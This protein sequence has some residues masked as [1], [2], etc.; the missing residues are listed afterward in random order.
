MQ[1]AIL[2]LI[3]GLLGW[4]G[5]HLE[6]WL[7]R[8]RRRATLRAALAAEILSLVEM[9]R[10]GRYEEELR[11]FASQLVASPEPRKFDSYFVHA[12]QSYFSVFEAN[13]GDIGELDAR[14][15]VE[16]IAFY[17]QARS[18]LDS[19]APELAPAV[20]PNTPEAS[21][22]HYTLRADTLAR[23]CDFG[24]ALAGRLASAEVAAHIVEV[25]KALDATASSV[26]P[27]GA[28]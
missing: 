15:A 14:L 18:W 3:G 27:A 24:T 12:P 9:V 2:V 8:L 4:G 1:E 5:A 20:G 10:R 22:A 13:A 7:Q 26:P 16:V 11:D 21:A 6:N 19:V 23:L 17:Q 25:A 28:P